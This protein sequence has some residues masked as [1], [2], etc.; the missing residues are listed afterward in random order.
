MYSSIEEVTHRSLMSSRCIISKRWGTCLM[1][2][3]GRRTRAHPPIPLVFSSPILS[4]AAFP[5]QRWKVV[6]GTDLGNLEDELDMFHQKSLG[7]GREG[8]IPRILSSAL[9]SAHVLIPWQC[10]AI[11][12]IQG[13]LRHDS[14]LEK[15]TQAPNL[16]V[17]HLWKCQRERLGNER[18]LARMECLLQ[19]QTTENFRTGMGGD[20]VNFT[21][22]VSSGSVLYPSPRVNTY[23][24]N[25]SKFTDNLL[26][27]MMLDPDYHSDKL[28]FYAWDYEGV[29]G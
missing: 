19:V 27:S 6:C 23:L 13:N 4:S 16:A 10:S 8:H 14:I 1:P 5:V 24:E 22:S 7:P 26:I 25:N 15:V 3:G 12:K 20:T 18:E 21:N 17:Y 2:A 28:S 9:Q 29:E 11:C